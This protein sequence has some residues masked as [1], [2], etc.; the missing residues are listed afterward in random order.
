MDQVLTDFKKG[1]LQKV[2]NYLEDRPSIEMVGTARRDI[3]KKTNIII[4][5]FRWL[6]WS[7]RRVDVDSTATRA[8]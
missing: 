4:E 3:L 5:A 7:M 8:L 1:Q 2:Y 6:I